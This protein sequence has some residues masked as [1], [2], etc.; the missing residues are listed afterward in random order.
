MTTTIPEVEMIQTEI[1]LAIQAD[2]LRHMLAE[3]R[4]ERRQTPRPTEALETAQTAL[5]DAQDKV[6]RLD[7]EKAD[8]KRL[9]ASLNARLDAGDENVTVDEIV[10]AEKSID[11]LDRLRK[12]AMKAVQEA[13]RTLKPLAADEHL[14]HLAADALEEITDVPVVIRKT[15]KEAPDIAPLIIVSQTK[16]TK[17]YGTLGCSGEVS[18]HTR[19]TSIDT[20]SLAAILASTGSEV[21]VHERGIRFEEARWSVP[22]LA[23]PSYGAFENYVNDLGRA[24]HGVVSDADLARRRREHGYHAARDNGWTGLFKVTSLDLAA[25]AG[26][27][28]GTAAISLAAQDH[29]DDLPHTILRN[30]LDRLIEIFREGSVGGHTAAGEIVDLSVTDSGVGK[31]NLW[32]DD[33]IAHAMGLASHPHTLDATVVVEFR[34]EPVEV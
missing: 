21:D 14:A 25:E 26:V 34:Y 22:R 9:L 7:Q 23:Q 10:S 2:Q 32:N 17:G 12:P 16:P 4:K 28:K 30:K 3:A 24:W 15:V 8:A 18:L 6:A 13:E 5:A 1:D 27:A 19:E 29:T 33:E 20:H 11:R 31:W